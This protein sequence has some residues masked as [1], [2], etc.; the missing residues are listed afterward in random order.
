EASAVP[1]EIQAPKPSP[2][3]EAP[4]EIGIEKDLEELFLEG[5]QDIVPVELVTFESPIRPPKKKKE[6]KKELPEEREPLRAIKKV[7]KMEIYERDELYEGKMR[8]RKE[9]KKEKKPLPPPIQKEVPRPVQ[10]VKP[11]IE[12]RPGKKRIKMGEAIIVGDLAKAMG[13]KAADLIKKLL[14]MGILATI[15]QALDYE[16]AA[17]LADEYGCEVEQITFKEEEFLQEEP[18]KE[19]DLRSRPPVVTVMGHVD[20]GKTTLLD[21]IRKTKVAEA[22][23]GG[24]TQHIGAYYV[25]TEQGGVVF[26]DTP[27]HEAFTAMRAR[28]AKVTDIIVLVVAADDGV[29]PQTK[30]A[31]NHAKAANIPIVVAINKIDK[32]NANPERVKRQLAELGLIPEE[33]GGDVIF[34]NISA[35]IGQGVDELLGLI[36]LQAEVMELKANPNKRAKG[37]IIEARLDK[38]KGPVATVLVKEGTLKVGDYFVA[39]E[40][41]GRVRAMFDHKGTRIKTAGPSI[42]V[43]IYGMPEVPN[44]GDELVVTP[45]EKTAKAL[46]EHRRSKAKEKESL[47][48][49]A[50]S[51][52]ELMEKIRQGEAKELNVV[53]RA[54]VQ[55]SLEAINDS[56]LKISKDDVRV[57]VIHSGTGA[58]TESDVMLAS[59]S[60]AIILGF[61]VRANPRAKELAE[62]E[63]V[64]VRYYDVIFVLLEDMEKAIKGMLEPVYEEKILGQVEVLQT[65]KVPKVG[66]VA[67]CIVRS[68]IA[69]RNAKVRIIRDGVVI[70]EGTIASLKRFKDDVKEVQEGME[71]GIALDRFQDIKVGDIF[72]VYALEEVEQ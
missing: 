61:N 19:E 72:E 64:Q 16:T 35:K 45:D 37:V 41:Y 71:C 39:G 31:I 46:G 25:K 34:G 59:A 11:E 15:N 20:H 36:L 68:G 24:I 1:D 40:V 66:V 49:K 54:D 9:K 5:G 21:Y 51:M 30:E 27:G 22:E 33:W 18:D 53:L 67:G 8:A 23:S 12:A 55:G 7:K 32:P 57:K 50:V 56:L 65:F 43:E 42:P 44:A 29:M 69:R 38:T 28:G 63:K 58:I 6:K 13:V 17:L 14:E 62:Q 47:K 4:K 2:E 3:S 60:N 10:E 52:E 70:H 48:V 26:L